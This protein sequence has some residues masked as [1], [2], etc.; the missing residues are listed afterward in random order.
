MLVWRAPTTL[1]NPSISEK[2][3]AREQRVDPQRF[4]REYLAEFGDD[5]EAF[6]P[7]VWIEQ[8]TVEDRH[9]LPAR[10]GVRYLATVDPSG[11]A[12]KGDSFTLSIVHVEDG[13]RFVQDVMKAWTSSRSATVDLG[14]VV[15]EI[16]GRYQ[17]AMVK[18][19]HYAGQWPEQEFR[20]V[21]ISYRASELDK[22]KAY[23]ELEPVLAQGRIELLDHPTLLR[24]LRLLERRYKPG[25]K[26]P[27]VDHP[28][29]GH[30]DCATA[31]ALGV[32][33]LAASLHPAVGFTAE[34]LAAA[35]AAAARRAGDPVAAGG[36][37]P[38][39]FFGRQMPRS[40]RSAPD[41]DEARPERAVS[42]LH[43][44]PGRLRMFR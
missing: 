36:E 7:G 42:L 39:G 41:E 4:A 17:L 13:Q 5:I 18:G 14:A 22:S 26:T 2:R 29:G 25:G 19:D 12:V 1:M 3:L 11:G 10:P 15:R 43:D 16:G 31:L 44:R 27:T 23:R 21:G 32:A 28:K 6:L 24:E 40:Q 34:S 30:D 8:A 20:K 33:E 38:V 35:R 9:E 37:L